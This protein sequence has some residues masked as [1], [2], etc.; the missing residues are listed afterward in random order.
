MRTL[1]L[2]VAVLLAVLVVLFTLPLQNGRPLLDRAYL[3]RHWQ[4]PDKLLDLEGLRGNKNGATELYRWRDTGG[5][6]QYGQIPPPGVHAERISITAP[7][8]I[9]AEQMRGGEGVGAAD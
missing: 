7:N 1:I 3:A 8:T 9:T 2:G 5:S 4:Q 6:W